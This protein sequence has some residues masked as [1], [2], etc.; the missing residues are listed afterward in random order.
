MTLNKGAI[1]TRSKKK[2]FF[3]KFLFWCQKKRMEVEKRKMI[4]YVESFK[5]VITCG[6][7]CPSVF[8]NRNNPSI[9]IVVEDGV[10]FDMSA[11]ASS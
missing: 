6:S 1:V 5:A 11:H 3:D 8:L 4:R 10:C 7:H 9:R 2:I